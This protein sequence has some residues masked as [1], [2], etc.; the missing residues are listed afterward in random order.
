MTT[1]ANIPPK[2]DK[3]LA[4]GPINFNPPNMINNGIKTSSEIVISHDEIT[5]KLEKNPFW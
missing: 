1:V 4:V 2:V 3:A 5:G